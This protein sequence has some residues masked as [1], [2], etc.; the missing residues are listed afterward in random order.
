[1]EI[2]YNE[3]VYIHEETKHIIYRKTPPLDPKFQKLIEKRNG[4][5]NPGKFDKD[6]KDS[7]SISPDECEKGINIWESF[8]E[9]IMQ[10]NPVIFYHE[11]FKKY[12]INVFKNFI[13]EGVFHLEVRALLGSVL[14]EV[15]FF[16]TKSQIFFICRKGE[17]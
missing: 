17:H 9:K 6:L 12:L 10:T 4:C 5:E 3:N 15:I 14:D 8:M 1:M 7:I 16:F 11:N 13:E 2:A